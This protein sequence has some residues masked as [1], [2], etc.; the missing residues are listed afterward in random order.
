MTPT[1]SYLLDG[2][3][4]ISYFIKFVNTKTQNTPAITVLSCF[5]LSIFYCYFSATSTAS[6]P[7]RVVQT[8]LYAPS[9]TMPHFTSVARSS[10]R[11]TNCS[12]V[13]PMMAMVM[14]PLMTLA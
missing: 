12:T 5:N 9:R 6:R 8:S 7:N 14:M 13:T 11:K 4:S 3:G 2:F 10:R 1:I